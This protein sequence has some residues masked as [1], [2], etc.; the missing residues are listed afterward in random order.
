MVFVLLAWTGL[1]I[2]TILGSLLGLFFAI[3]LG[4]I[5]ENVNR[6]PSVE[7]AIYLLTFYIV[8]PIF[9]VIGIVVSGIISIF[10]M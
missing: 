7:D 1:L 10:I 5:W 8:I 4:I 9:M 3:I 2:P 6:D